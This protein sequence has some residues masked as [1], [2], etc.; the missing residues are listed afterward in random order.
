MTHNEPLELLYPASLLGAAAVGQLQFLSREI[1]RASF[2]AFDRTPI[3]GD[4]TRQGSQARVARE[5]LQANKKIIPD[6]DCLGQGTFHGGDASYFR[7][8]K[9]E[10]YRALIAQGALVGTVQRIA[11]KCWGQPLAIK[12]SGAFLYPDTG[13]MGWHT[14]EDK[15]GF[16]AYLVYSHEE[17]QSFFRYEDPRSGKLVT[18]WDPL[19]WSFRTFAVGDDSKTRLWHCVYSQTR[20]ASLG[21]KLFPTEHV[22]PPL[23][24][25]HALNTPDRTVDGCD[26]T[27]GGRTGKIPL[28]SVA[29][30]LV[31]RI[32]ESLCL[33]DVCHRDRVAS[34]ERF[35]ACDTRYP[36]IVVRA[37]ENPCGKPYRLIDG[38]HR[39]HRLKAEGRSRAMF[40][41]LEPREVQGLII[42]HD[43]T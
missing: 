2:T 15:P 1:L 36:P 32:A 35:E 21:F 19:G 43:V 26:W 38:N 27:L 34:Q 16:R 23:R 30:L 17:H 12:T 20:R 37:M 18:S 14:N 25:A 9:W 41:V 28:R 3:D 33:K 31:G 5:A 4:A 11:E 6:G 40:Y 42:Y 10:P 29:P 24:G 13:F 7:L 22:P 39:I 8:K